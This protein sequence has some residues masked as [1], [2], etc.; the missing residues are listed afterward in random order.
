M[1]GTR[2]AAHL[3]AAMK[4]AKTHDERVVPCAHSL[5]ALLNGAKVTTA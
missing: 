2:E 3:T 1:N 5:D 4:S